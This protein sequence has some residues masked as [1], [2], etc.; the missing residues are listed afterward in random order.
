MSSSDS[1]STKIAPTLSGSEAISSE[2]SSDESLFSARSGTS[3]LSSS[4]F[5]TTTSDSSLSSIATLPELAHHRQ[6]KQPLPGKNSHKGKVEALPHMAKSNMANQLYNFSLNKGNRFNEKTY[7]K[8]KKFYDNLFEKFP[9]VPKKITVNKDANLLNNLS[10]KKK[11]TKENATLE[12]MKKE[13]YQRRICQKLDVPW[14][15]D[16]FVM[17]HLDRDDWYRITAAWKTDLL[18]KELMFGAIMTEND[19]RRI[20]LKDKKR[21]LVIF[22]PDKNRLTKSEQL[23]TIIFQKINKLYNNYQK[24][25]NK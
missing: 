5:W 15:N 11:V 23:Y 10:Q 19:Y 18:S 13:I 21:L 1:D 12:E 17:Y 20:Y 7:L 24:I 3:S 14:N 22:H 4:S 8:N 16:L 2:A 6:K 25:N 9:Q